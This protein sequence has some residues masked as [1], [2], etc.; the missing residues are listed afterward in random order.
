MQPFKVSIRLVVVYGRDSQGTLTGIVRRSAIGQ[1]VLDP[2][3][4]APLIV[5]MVGDTKAETEAKK[6]LKN[7]QHEIMIC[8]N[9]LI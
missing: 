6:H 1:C 9:L 3:P 8:L 5:A 2:I 7:I 4:L